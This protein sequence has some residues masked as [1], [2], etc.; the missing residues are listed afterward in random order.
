VNRNK[1]GKNDTSCYNR[2]N[3]FNIKLKCHPLS[4]RDHGQ[5]ENSEKGIVVQV[6]KDFPSRLVVKV[7]FDEKGTQIDPPLDRDLKKDLTLYIT[8][9]AN[10]SPA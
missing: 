1:D 6:P 10:E 4:H 7:M 5:L 3:K 9:V 8:G 2:P